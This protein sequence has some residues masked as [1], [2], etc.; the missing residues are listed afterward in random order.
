MEPNSDHL[1]H[2][3]LERDPQAKADWETYRKLKQP[4]PRITTRTARIIRKTSIDELPQ[5]WNVLV[6]NM[7]LVGPRPILEDEAQLFGDTLNHYF[8]VRPGIT[9]LWQVSGRNDTSFQ[10]RVYWDGW[11]VR[12][13]SLWGDIVILFKTLSVVFGRRGAF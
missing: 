3:L 5:I 6:G 9:G 13:W 8:R 1:L 10:R 7:S 11:Y 2:E 4:D 12:N